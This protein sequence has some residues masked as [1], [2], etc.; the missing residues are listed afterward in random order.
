MGVIVD[1]AGIERDGARDG[2]LWWCRSP[3]PALPP[4]AEMMHARCSLT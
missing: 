4:C 2:V 3:P 1:D